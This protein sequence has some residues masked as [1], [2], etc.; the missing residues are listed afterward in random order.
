MSRARSHN[1]TIDFTFGS[2]QAKSTQTLCWKDK[3]KSK[4][5]HN[6]AN[7]TEWHFMQVGNLYHILL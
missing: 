6:G 7:L 3:Y 1:E 2:M 5:K 4:N